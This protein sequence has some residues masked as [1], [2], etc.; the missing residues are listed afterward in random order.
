MALYKK[1][2]PRWNVLPIIAGLWYPLALH[3]PGVFGNVSGD[4]IS[5]A[6][7]TLTALQGAALAALGY[8]LKSDAPEETVAP[9]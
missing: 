7:F 5:I 9:V 8:I 2:L 1:P 6:A 3:T 4:L